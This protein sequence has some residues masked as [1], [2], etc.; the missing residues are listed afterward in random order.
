MGPTT[1]LDGQ[2][3]GGG[4]S[5]ARVGR[6]HDEVHSLLGPPL[7]DR[8]AIGGRLWDVLL[9]AA[10]PSAH[11]GGW[12]AAGQVGH[13]GK[14]SRESMWLP[15]PVVNATMRDIFLIKDRTCMWCEEGIFFSIRKPPPCVCGVCGVWGE[16]FFEFGAPPRKLSQPTCHS[17]PGSQREGGRQRAIFSVA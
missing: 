9:V 14:L 10:S 8:E 1:A 13:V 4:V 5:D 6:A 2:V 3:G 15:P 16:I 17:F 11:A 12:V 7:K